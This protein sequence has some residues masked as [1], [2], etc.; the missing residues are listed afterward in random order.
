MHKPVMLEEMINWISPKD[1]GTYIDGTF[2]AGGYSR[3]ILNSADCK[4]KT[5]ARSICACRGRV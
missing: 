4:V 2:G 3:A 1:K 5:M